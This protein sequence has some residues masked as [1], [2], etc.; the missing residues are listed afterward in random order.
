LCE[1]HMVFLGNNDVPPAVTLM[2][3]A[4]GALF[5]TVSQT[6]VYANNNRYWTWFL[7]DIRSVCGNPGP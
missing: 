7:E 4:D 5:G 1:K 3:A 2:L 6:R